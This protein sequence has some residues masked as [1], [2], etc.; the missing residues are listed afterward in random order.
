MYRAR[1]HR[2]AASRSFLHVERLEIAAD[3]SLCH[4][5]GARWIS[6]HTRCIR[7]GASSGGFLPVLLRL[8]IDRGP[9]SAARVI[10]PLTRG[11]HEPTR[12]RRRGPRQRRAALRPWTRKI[13]LPHVRCISPCLERTA[14][15]TG[16]K[17]RSGRRSMQKKQQAAPERRS[18]SKGRTS[19]ILQLKTRR[20]R[21]ESPPEAIRC[22]R[23]PR[24]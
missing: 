12:R 8:S 10:R 6:R 19:W 18:R 3:C 16:E 7:H 9:T 4:A 11:R 5:P 2:I 21:P 13:R 15:P 20:L 14:D 22:D 23:G 24:S 1:T 17:R